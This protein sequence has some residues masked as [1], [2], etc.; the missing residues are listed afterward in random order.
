MLERVVELTGSYAHDVRTPHCPAL[1]L[2]ENKKEGGR[3]GGG[4]GS[5]GREGWKGGRSY[6][7]EEQRRNFFI[8]ASV[9]EP[10][11][12]GFNTALSLNLRS[13][14]RCFIQDFICGAHIFHS[15]RPAG[16][17]NWLANGTVD[18]E[19]ERDTAANT[20]YQS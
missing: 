1:A 4:G 5:G 14:L 9:S 18:V 11:T 8:G 10:H 3:G 13:I 19:R 6:Y 16:P 15:A 17:T 2:Q 7:K 12:S 20:H